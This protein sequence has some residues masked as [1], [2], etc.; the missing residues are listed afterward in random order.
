MAK[1]KRCK[2]GA[3][4]D[5]VL[6]VKSGGNPSLPEDKVYQCNQKSTQ[7]CPPKGGSCKCCVVIIHIEVVAG[8]EEETEELSFP[9]QP[10]TR[11]D[12]PY[13]GMLTQKKVMDDYRPSARPSGPGPHAYWR[14]VGRCLEVDA[15]GKPLVA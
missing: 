6:A 14:I 5:P 9:A 10:D 12:K 15:D 13:D 11:K 8:G 2:S 7:P 4:D 1:F 3:C